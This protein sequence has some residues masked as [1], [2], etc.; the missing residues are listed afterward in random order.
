MTD[1][2]KA[3]ILIA[4]AVLPA[5]VVAVGPAKVACDLSGGTWYEF[6]NGVTPSSRTT[7]GLTP[8]THQWTAQVL[9]E[10]APE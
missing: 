10:Y 1:T 5:T 8:E 7:H 3:A 4:V 2:M 9:N 6:S